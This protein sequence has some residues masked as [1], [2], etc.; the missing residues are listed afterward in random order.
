LLSPSLKRKEEEKK[1]K[2]KEAKG[3][4]QKET[5]RGT[6]PP[7]WACYSNV[8]RVWA[9][10]FGSFKLG[11]KMFLSTSALLLSRALLLEAAKFGGTCLVSR[12]VH[13]HFSPQNL[14]SRPP[15]IPN[16]MIPGG[17]ESL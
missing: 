15:T 9:P 3:E 12:G 11:I 6:L 8:P 7:K 10:K 16:H 5:P 4:K 1:R 14:H 2:R 17:M 13:P